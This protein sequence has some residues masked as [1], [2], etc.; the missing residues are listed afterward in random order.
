MMPEERDKNA[1]PIT[2][3]PV[4]RNVDLHQVTIREQRNEPAKPIKPITPT[5][6]IAVAVIIAARINFNA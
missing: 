2:W 1:A 5:K 6:L 3:L 4:R